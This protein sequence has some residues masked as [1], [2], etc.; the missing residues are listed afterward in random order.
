MDGS[1][2]RRWLSGAAQIPN[3]VKVALRLMLEA[4]QQHREEQRPPTSDLKLPAR[5]R[6]RLTR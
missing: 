1:T 6:S 5:P 3:P 2:V 4:R